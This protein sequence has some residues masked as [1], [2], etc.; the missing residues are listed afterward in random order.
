VGAVATLAGAAAF[1]QKRAHDA[2]A[3][4]PPKGR[5]V[6][7]DGVRLHY[8]E[9]GSGD[10]L[11]LL[12]GNGALVEDFA[13]SGLI[14]LA[15]HRYR[16]IT[17]DR[18]GYGYSER[19]RSRVWTPEAQAALF[20][21]AFRELGIERPIVL[22]HSWG[23]QV[24]VSLGLD[25]A[26]SVRSLVLLSGYY[27]PSVRID[28]GL[29]SPPAIPVLGDLLRYTVSPLVGRLTWPLILRKLFGPNPTPR[30][31]ERFPKWMVLRPGQIRASAEE[32]ALM[33]PSAAR[34]SRRYGQLT[35]PVV[36]M[37]GDADR[38]VTMANQSLRLHEELDGSGFH[39]VPGVGHM[40]HHIVPDAVLE[41]IDEAAESGTA[42]LGAAA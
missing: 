41:A 6:E 22:G 32:T 4:N 39:A 5:F 8:T 20:A 36:I 29:L 12:H 11:V 40:I 1:V 19:P 25:W 38:V 33:I 14:E 21:A 24:A 13:T 37:A 35:V 28:V 27:Y 7:V 10:P 2:E 42:R 18:P 31:M 34:L 15:S 3:A 30:H 23:T 9:R 26:Q 16:V 17:F